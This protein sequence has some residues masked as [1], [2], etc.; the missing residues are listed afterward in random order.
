MAATAVTIQA[1]DQQFRGIFERVWKVKATIDFASALT[2]AES[3]DTVA[4]PGVAL[5]DMVIACSLGVDVVDLV[6]NA[7]V[8]AANEV[9]VVVANVTGGTVD[10][11]STTIKL[12]VARPNF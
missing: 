12:V 10:L 4:V 11:A 6:V 5:G 7:N 9:S 3:A 1:G 8:T 2:A